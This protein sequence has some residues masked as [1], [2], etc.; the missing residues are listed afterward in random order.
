M[1]V[2]RWR[3][4]YLKVWICC[5]L[6]RGWGL[7]WPP[8]GPKISSL[9]YYTIKIWLKRI[10]DSSTT[11]F[12]QVTKSASNSGESSCTWPGLGLTPA[13]ISSLKY[14]IRW[15]LKL[16]ELFVIQLLP[17]LMCSS[18][19]SFMFINS[20]STSA[21]ISSTGSPIFKIVYSDVQLRRFVKN[22]FINC[23][24]VSFWLLHF[25]FQSLSLFIFGVFDILERGEMVHFLGGKSVKH[26]G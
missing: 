19:S 20:S 5:L 13:Y 2:G 12:D 16:N 7:A 25:S 9:P 24:C 3:Q 14:Y 17:V 15:H 4:I 8:Q 1:G 6:R 26:R 23:L 21:M 11:H 18:S 22:W 10:L